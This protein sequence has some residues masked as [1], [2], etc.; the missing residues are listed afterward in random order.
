[1]F[2]TFFLSGRKKY[3]K[4]SHFQIKNEWVLSFF[5]DE[6]AKPPAPPKIDVGNV[7]SEDEPDEPGAVTPKRIS[8]PVESILNAVIQ[9]GDVIELFHILCYRL[10]EININQRNHSGLTALHYA[11]LTNNLD[12]VK[13]LIN[14]GA[15]V[16]VQDMYGFSPLHTAAALGYLHVTALL[17]V[18]GADVFSLTNQSELPVDLAKDISVIR[19]LSCEMCSRLQ[20][21]Q[22]LKSLALYYVRR[23]GSLTIQ[24]L[25][26]ICKAVIVLMHQMLSKSS[27]Y[28]APYLSRYTHMFAKRRRRSIENNTN[29]TAVKH[30]NFTK[31]LSGC[32]KTLT[33][34]SSQKPSVSDLSLPNKRQVS[35]KQD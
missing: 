24:C 19:L 15:D 18:Y 9:D 21:E 30:E 29:A 4:E 35:I 10:S 17:V 1:M 14:Y 31:K 2:K 25:L 5:L 26:L 13:L 32:K 16:S 6:M 8:F 20:R 28:I 3:V 11:V 27:G 12:S 33:P 7:S 34:P 22:H 23:T